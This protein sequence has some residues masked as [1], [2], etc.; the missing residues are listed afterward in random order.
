MQTHIC[1]APEIYSS[2][3][4]DY[5]G[6]APALAARRLPPCE[7]RWDSR[8]RSVIG[9]LERMLEL[10][11]RQPEPDLR[12]ELDRLLSATRE[13]LAAEERYMALVQFPGASEHRLRHQLICLATAKLGCLAGKARPALLGELGRLRLLWLEHIEQHDRLFEEFLVPRS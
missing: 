5:P 2:P 7:P 12:G 9:R 3:P 11:L 6:P 8:F 13:Q 4:T 1:P 10:G